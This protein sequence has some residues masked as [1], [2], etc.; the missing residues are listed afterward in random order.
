MGRRAGGP[1]ISNW[2]MVEFGPHL[3][4]VPALVNPGTFYAK[5]IMPK[6][7]GYYGPARDLQTLSNNTVFSLGLPNRIAG[8]VHSYKKGTGGT[9]FLYAGSTATNAG[10]AQL[11]RYTESTKTW[12]DASQAGGY[13][14]G[15]FRNWRF[16]N[17][18]DAVIAAV[19][20]GQ[21]LQYLADGSTGLF[22][23]LDANAP[24]AVDIAVVNPGFLV[25]INV[26]DNVHGAGTQHYRAWWSGI[27]DPTSW[28]QPATTAAL[29]VQS[30]F[31][32]LFGGGRLRR[33]F[34]GIGGNDAVIVGERHIWRMN[35]VGPPNIF[36]FRVAEYDQGTTIDGSCVASNETLYYYGH[37]GFMAFDGSNST[38]IG[39]GKVDQTFLDEIEFVENNSYE[40]AVCA[41]F[42]NDTA[43]ALW[44]YRTNT[45]TMDFNNVVRAYN[46][47]TGN[48][49][50]PIEIGVD[51]MGLVDNQTTFTDVPHLVVM[52]QDFHLQR[53][54]GNTLEAEIDTRESAVPG[55]GETMF[56]SARPIIDAD[57]IYV[58]MLTR[59]R[60]SQSL[61]ES[62]EIG[63][64]DDGTCPVDA[65][66][67]RY[68]RARCRIPAGIEWKDAIGVE[69]EIAPGAHGPGRNG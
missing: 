23:D 67:A 47:I 51:A 65:D 64:E 8:T 56:K 43:T 3:P 53:L 66:Y 54:T 62:G 27:G 29:N 46:T 30:D 16:T 9:V 26:V 28:E 38:P 12:S 63:Q 4:D 17:M 13:T 42:D 39:R 44:S 60:I 49:S 37:G 22:A 52:G 57:E 10:D 41:G 18:G 33:I 6:A 7:N 48:W 11:F 45:A 58:K 1:S 59:D 68:F 31:Q 32:D 36:D 21:V 5:N 19:G 2:P 55:G 24:D 14:V 61:I 20:H 69:G 25:A 40:F 50:P 34:P 15:T 35:Y